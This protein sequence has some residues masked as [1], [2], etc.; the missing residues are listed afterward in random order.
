MSVIPLPPRI[1]VNIIQKKKIEFRVS[2]MSYLICPLYTKYYKVYVYTT[3]EKKKKAE[4]P[5]K[6]N[7][8]DLEIGI[9][10]QGL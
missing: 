1:K 10:R 6:Q 4:C 5:L 2:K 8:D 3:V 9:R 7:Q